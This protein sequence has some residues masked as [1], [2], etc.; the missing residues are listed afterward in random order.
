MN[1][2][3]FDDSENIDYFQ[4]LREHII[5]TLTCIFNSISGINKQ[6]E[7]MIY[8]GPIF[9]FINTICL[10]QKCISAEILKSSL[11]LIGDFCKAYGKNIKNL[12]NPNVVQS[13]IEN[14]KKPMIYNSDQNIGK[15]IH[16]GQ[17]M[18]ENVLSS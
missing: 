12:I 5:E 7:F 13:I 14:L 2:Q 15:T 1:I 4:D 9:T 8:V 18:V 6:D 17:K 3:N 16:Y 10:D 11:G